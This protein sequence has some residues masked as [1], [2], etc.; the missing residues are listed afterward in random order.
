[1]LTASAEHNNKFHQKRVTLY[2]MMRGKIQPPFLKNMTQ[3]LEMHFAQLEDKRF[4]AFP[5][6]MFVSQKGVVK[7]CHRRMLMGLNAEVISAFTTPDKITL[8]GLKSF[9]LG[10]WK[11][12]NGFNLKRELLRHNVQF[13]EWVIFENHATQ[14]Q[15]QSYFSQSRRTAICLEDLQD[16]FKTI[17][18]ENQQGDHFAT[19]INSHFL[20]LKA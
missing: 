20:P 17:T 15:F 18:D 2:R 11:W 8:E 4:V 14:V 5:S 7:M 9:N 13:P 6:V 12:W 1:G 3:A 19:Y 10:S 16:E